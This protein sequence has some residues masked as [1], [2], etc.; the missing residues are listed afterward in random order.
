MGLQIINMPYVMNPTFVNPTFV[1]QFLNCSAISYTATGT[2]F[3]DAYNGYAYAPYTLTIA[4]EQTTP[5]PEPSGLILL[6]TDELLP[7]LP[8]SASPAGPRRIAARPEPTHYSPVAE[9]A[10]KGP[11]FKSHLLKI[12]RKNRGRGVLPSIYRLPLPANAK[13]PL[14]C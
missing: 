7:P 9:A 4:Q 8:A 1:S 12:L 5:T 11:P 6:A 13:P 14:Q 3:G 10:H 2:F